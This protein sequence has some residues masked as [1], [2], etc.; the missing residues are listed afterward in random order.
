MPAAPSAPITAISAVGQQPASD[1][2]RKT[3]E[4][5]LATYQAVAKNKDDAVVNQLP[6]FKETLERLN[7]YLSPL[8]DRN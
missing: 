7:E 6:E 3:I 5:I 8:K 1:A 2:E 4:G